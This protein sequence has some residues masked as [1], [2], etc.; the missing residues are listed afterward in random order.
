MPG[1]SERV[2][3]GWLLAVLADCVSEDE[4]VELDSSGDGVVESQ[5][6]PMLVVDFLLLLY[7]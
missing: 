4:F 2:L 1:D 6:V 3:E 5:V 7:S